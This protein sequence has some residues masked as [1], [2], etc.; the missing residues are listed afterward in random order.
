MKKHINAMSRFFLKRDMGLFFIRVALGLLFLAHG[1]SKVNNL[2]STEAMFS[3]MGF[4]PGVA[5][6]IAYLEVVGGVALILGLATRVFAVVFGIEMLVAVL[7]SPL[8]RAIGGTEL[9]LSLASF[10]IALTGSGRFSLY[11]MECRK[12][13][14]MLCDSD[15]DACIAR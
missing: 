14:G 5:V 12:C 7:I 3:H 2:P 13:G 6:L 8:T 11:A 15:N 10:G 4:S 9:L 1:W